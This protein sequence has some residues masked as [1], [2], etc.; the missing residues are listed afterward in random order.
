[1]SDREALVD[2]IT[3]RVFARLGTSPTAAPSKHSCACAPAPAAESQLREM[4]NQGA[5]R[6]ACYEKASRLPAEIAGTIDHTLL[7]PDAVEADF[8]VLCQEARDFGFA[9]VCVNPGWV[10]L[11]AQLLAGSQVAVCTVIGFPLGATA[12][13]SKAFETRWAVENGATEVDM[14]INVGALKS[15][16]YAR[17]LA[18]IQAVVRAADGRA[19]TKVILETSLLDDEQKVVACTLAKDA[20]AD[21][22][23]TSTGFGGGGATAEDIALMRR[24][25]GSGLGVKASGGVRDR[26]GADAMIAAGANRIGASA[27]VKIVQGGK[28]KDGY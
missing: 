12:T 25:V 11:C 21:Y 14:V 10:P 22:V 4:V 3:E 19:C 28:G 23:K 17:V 20:C 1:M 13:E 7:K 6:L 24:V 26:A 27:G 18:D 9:S 5:C 15:G 2:R 8:R 16:D